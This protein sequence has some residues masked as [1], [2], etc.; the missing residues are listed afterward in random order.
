MKAERDAT[1]VHLRVKDKLGYTRTA[2]GKQLD[3]EVRLTNHR[4]EVSC[5]LCARVLAEPVS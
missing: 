5:P 2:C 1:P 4:D 3:W